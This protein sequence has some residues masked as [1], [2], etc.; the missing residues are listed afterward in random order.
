MLQ[1]DSQFAK[2]YEKG[3]NKKDYWDP[4]YEDSLNL[5]AKLPGIAAI[6]YRNTYFG[7]NKIPHDNS[8]DW[9]ANLAHQMGALT[10]AD[11]IAKLFNTSLLICKLWR[12][13][14]AYIMEHAAHVEAGS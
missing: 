2:A 3:V 9:A 10:L 12:C 7:G 13:A 5:I 6:I 4:I 1:P 8:L 11:D 14:L